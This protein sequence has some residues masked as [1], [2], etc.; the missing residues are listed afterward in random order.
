C[1]LPVSLPSEEPFAMPGRC[2]TAFALVSA[3]AA[4]ARAQ[5]G[6]D[7]RVSGIVI[8]SASGAPLRATVTLAPL[9]REARTD[10]A[11]RFA[12]AAVQPGD[13]TLTATA[14]GYRASRLTVRVPGGIETTLR[15]Q[16]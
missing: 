11:G 12:F 8:D 5:T 15:V 6:P 14:F 4:P 3:L 1:C 9:G 10:S 7:A 2:C 13:L 16:L